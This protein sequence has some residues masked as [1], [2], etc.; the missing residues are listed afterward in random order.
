VRR[1]RSCDRHLMCPCVKKHVVRW[2]TRKRGS[3]ALAKLIRSGLCIGYSLPATYDQRPAT[4]YDSAFSDLQ[5]DR[6]GNRDFCVRTLCE[7]PMKRTVHPLARSRVKVDLSKISLD[8]QAICPDSCP[9]ACPDSCPD[10]C[11]DACLG[12]YGT[13]PL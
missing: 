9:D 4:G 13:Y 11:P 5:R 7:G 8:L 6:H 3:H 2:N 1:Y 10:A 12:A